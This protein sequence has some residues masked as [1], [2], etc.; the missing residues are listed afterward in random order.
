MLLG[1]QEA[2]EA[3]KWISNALL[4]AA[5]SGQP[6]FTNT[7]SRTQ[8]WRMPWWWPSD[9]TIGIWL[10]SYIIWIKYR[11]SPDAYSV[12]PMGHLS[13]FWELFGS[14]LSFLS[15]PV[16][17]LETGDCTHTSERDLRAQ[18][19]F[20]LNGCADVGTT[21]FYLFML[22]SS[23]KRWINFLIRKMHRN[24]FLLKSLLSLVLFRQRRSPQSVF[25]TRVGMLTVFTFL[26]KFNFSR[27]VL[28]MWT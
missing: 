27:M 8:L 25:T 2:V 4:Y 12:K 22:P 9:F 17:K 6:L 13:H 21:A 10:F 19:T 5:L 16:R 14:F 23:S 18:L 7:N 20:L 24:D 26:G 28:R 3:E 1:S 11:Y 15:S